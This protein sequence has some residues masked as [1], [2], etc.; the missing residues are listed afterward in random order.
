M[1]RKNNNSNKET[2][3][4]EK[5]IT[6]N[7][8]EIKKSTQA[9]SNTDVSKPAINLS[10]STKYSDGIPL[11]NNKTEVRKPITN[12]PAQKVPENSIDNIAKLV[13][14]SQP[15]PEMIKLNTPNNTTIVP[16]HLVKKLK[17][18]SL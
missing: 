18:K 10:L 12:Y 5:K 4:P 2:N 13:T 1:D 14:E 7:T 15:L 17:I 11:A 9:I 8:G 6:Q 3:I 16:I